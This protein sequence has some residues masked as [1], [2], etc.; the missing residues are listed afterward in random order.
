MSHPLPTK[1]DYLI[2]KEGKRKFCMVVASA[3]KDT[4]KGHL[5]KNS[6]LPGQKFEVEV[7]P[8]SVVLNLGPTPTPGSVYGASIE[9]L[10]GKKFHE[11]FGHI[12]FMYPIK[13]EE[14][15]AL[16]QSFE[17][18]TKILKKHGLLGLAGNGVWE[19]RSA[20]EGGKYAGTYRHS[21]SDKHPHVYCIRPEK[22][23]RDLYPYVIL[24]ELAHHARFEYASSP[25]IIASW[26]K[27]FNTTIKLRPISKTDSVKYLEELMSSKD[28][29]PS[30][31]GS[32]LDAEQ[33]TDYK[34]ILAVI[35]RHHAISPRELD[36]LYE[37][38]NFEAIRELWPQRT[39]QI[40][41]LKPSVSEY[42]TTKVEELIAEAISFYLTGKKLPASL[43]KL[44][45]KT[46]SYIKTQIK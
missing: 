45:E 17:I 7:A 13:K 21:K 19:V 22:C 42:A 29:L 5:S 24:H 32:T 16:M 46:L 3:V 33:T 30:K 34:H 15:G 40:K 2:A 39:I 12:A 4:I 41:E 9:V 37:T 20:D 23:P 6:H 38:D 8:S 28:V 43:T 25:R 27:E 44:T 18:A 14:G 11:V 36:T 35:R 10:R 31:F 1:G 26:I